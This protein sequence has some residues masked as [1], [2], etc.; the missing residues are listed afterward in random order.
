MGFTLLMGSH[1][2][3]NTS[4]TAFSFHSS[5]IYATQNDYTG[6]VAKTDF[7]SLKYKEKKK[8]ESVWVQLQQEEE[9]KI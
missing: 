6:T 8:C 3:I 9:D 2:G 1:E 7:E 4:M 5:N